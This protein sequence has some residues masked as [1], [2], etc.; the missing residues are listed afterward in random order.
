[1]EGGSEKKEK[2]MEKEESK[3]ESKRG[4]KKNNG[5]INYSDIYYQLKTIRRKSKTVNQGSILK[6][7]S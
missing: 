5:L 6:T 4:E 2:K 7:G 1:M 3:E